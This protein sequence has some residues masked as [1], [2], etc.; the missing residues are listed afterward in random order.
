[1]QGGYGKRVV[2]S[3][4]CCQSD[5]QS[6]TYTSI[7]TAGQEETPRTRCAVPA[8]PLEPCTIA[9]AHTELLLV[10]ARGGHLCFAQCISV[11]GFVAII[12]FN[13]Y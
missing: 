1:M 5:M 11:I 6:M 4:E 8:V 3:R 7:W 10:A 13:C 12:R 2:G 9:H